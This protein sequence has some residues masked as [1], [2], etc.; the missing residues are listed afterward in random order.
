MMKIIDSNNEVVHEILFSDMELRAA[1]F[2]LNLHIGKTSA[3]V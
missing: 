2:F 1:P 3:V